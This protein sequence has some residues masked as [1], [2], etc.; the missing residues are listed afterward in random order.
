[1]PVRIPEKRSLDLVRIRLC[2]L[3]GER[4]VHRSE[5]IGFRPTVRKHEVVHI[6][7]RHLHACRRCDIG[8]LQ[9]HIV[10]TSVLE[11][12]CIGIVAWRQNDIGYLGQKRSVG[13][14]IEKSHAEHAFHEI[15]NGPDCRLAV[16]SAESSTLLRLK[17]RVQRRI[18]SGE[19]DTALYG[20]HDKTFRRQSRNIDSESVGSG[21]SPNI[22]DRRPCG[23][24]FRRIVNRRLPTCLP[25][26]ELRELPH[27]VRNR[28]CFLRKLSFMCGIGHDSKHRLSV[29]HKSQRLHRIGL[30]EPD[31]IESLVLKR[32]L[33][34]ERQQRQQGNNK[35]RLH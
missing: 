19:N 17:I 30:G 1:M 23:H 34:R 32:H 5:R 12:R 13:S 22:N 18:I 31:R 10:R 29:F 25:P 8:R 16:A 4:R 21:A 27:G 2:P 33:G 35:Q 28:L 24:L 20:F 6:L 26:Y 15:V 3:V 7:L 14:G 11:T 9:K